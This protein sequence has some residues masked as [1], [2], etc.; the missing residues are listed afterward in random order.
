MARQYNQYDPKALQTIFLALLIGQLLFG[1]VVWWLLTENGTFYFNLS[2]T[3]LLVVPLLALLLDYSG[4][5]FYKNGFKKQ[6]PTEDVIDRLGRLQSAHIVRFAL[7]EAGTLLLLVMA[8]LYENQFYLLFATL[9]IV[10]F[11]SLRPR[12]IEF[13]NT[14]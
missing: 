14:Y 12:I 5:L 9:N 6:H 13:N 4:N 10:Y 3:T 1:F 2:E 7:T 8:L 11:I